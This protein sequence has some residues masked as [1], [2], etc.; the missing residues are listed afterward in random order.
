MTWQPVSELGFSRMGFIRT[1]G[2]R[3]QAW[4]CTTWARP[5]SPPS[6]STNELS[7]MFWALNGATRMPSCKQDPAQGRRQHA[8]A[9]V[10]TGAL[11]HQGRRPGG[12]SSF[13]PDAAAA[14][15]AANGIA[16]PG[17]LLR[18][19]HGHA[20]ETGV[21][22][23]LGGKRAD[24]DALAKQAIGQLRGRHVAPIQAGPAGNS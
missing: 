6:R 1:S 15:A 20:E 24:G 21:E 17:V 11:E 13:G 18:R 10:G 7:D 9:G 2:S 22:M 16:Q 8:L 4:A 14:S 5:I 3:R 19:A 12:G 23:L